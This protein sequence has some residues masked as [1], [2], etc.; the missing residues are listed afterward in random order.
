MKAITEKFQKRPTLEKKEKILLE[1]TLKIL[2]QSQ[3]QEDDE[4]LSY[5]IRKSLLSLFFFLS[6]T[7]FWL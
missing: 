5:C 6:K 4:K 3:H 1:E 2:V 7:F